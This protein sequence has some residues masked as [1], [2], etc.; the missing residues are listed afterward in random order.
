MSINIDTD[1]DFDDVEE[2]IKYFDFDE[3]QDLV[4]KALQVFS[5]HLPFWY[6]FSVTYTE[7]KAP[8][9]DMFAM[10]QSQ[11]IIKYGQPHIAIFA[12]TI[13]DFFS[14]KQERFYHGIKKFKLKQSARQ[15][16]LISIYHELCKAVIEIDDAYEFIED[17][18]FLI[19]KGE[20]KY[21]TDFATKF[22]KT[23]SVPSEMKKLLKAYSKYKKKGK[24]DKYLV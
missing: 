23:E 15:A 4:E 10:Y 19:F 14:G 11:S 22:L 1:I 17:E 5:F 20:D 3:V 6:D 24:L 16:I 8:S 7:I 9:A 18:N 12:K 21:C 2:T 13:D